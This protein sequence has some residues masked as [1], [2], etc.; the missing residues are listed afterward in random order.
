MA[1]HV[2]P[3]VLVGDVE[4]PALNSGEEHVVSLEDV[5]ALVTVVTAAAFTKSS[6]R[7][8][9][10]PEDVKSQK[11][12]GVKLKGKGSKTMVALR[13]CRLMRLDNVVERDA[14]VAALREPPYRTI[15]SVH[16]QSL[17][18]PARQDLTSFW[19][20]LEKR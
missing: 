14:L 5:A 2:K 3:F 10:Y 19:D 16:F 9:S 7:A 11:T 1:S 6:L 18:D 8:T 13:G 12:D 4:L 15:L 20:A 17:L